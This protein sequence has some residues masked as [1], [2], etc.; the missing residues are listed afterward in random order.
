MRRN[1]V[2]RHP[3]HPRGDTPKRQR[4]AVMVC[5]Q[6]GIGAVGAK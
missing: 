3:G 5:H 2:H 6:D 4:S 1:D